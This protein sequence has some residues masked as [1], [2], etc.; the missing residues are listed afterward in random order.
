VEVMEERVERVG[1]LTLF[2]VF[3]AFSSMTEEVRKVRRATPKKKGSRL[4][5]VVTDKVRF[6]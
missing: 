3:V 6:T 1:A 4:P 5:S 2:W